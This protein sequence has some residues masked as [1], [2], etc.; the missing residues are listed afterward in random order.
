MQNRPFSHRPGVRQNARVLQIFAR[1]ATPKRI[2]EATPLRDA[3]TGAV[4]PKA[5]AAAL[6]GHQCAKSAEN[7]PPRRWPGLDSRSRPTHLPAQEAQAGASVSG[8]HGADE[9]SPR[10]EDVS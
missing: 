4:A 7:R 8:Y 10:Q 6:S 9:K 3:A 2:A 5:A 1:N